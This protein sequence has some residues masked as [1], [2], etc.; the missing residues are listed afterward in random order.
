MA[1]IGE[2]FKET[3]IERTK[4]LPQFSMETIENSSLESLRAQNES[5][6]AETALKEQTETERDAST[7]TKGLTEEEK[8]Q[9]KDETGWSDEVIDAIRSTEECD[10]YKNAGLRE[11][12]INGRECLVRS[13]IDWD[14]QDDMGRTNRERAEA[15]LS[16]INKDGD[17]IELHHIGQKSDASLA[18][19]TPDEH[20]SKENYSVLHDTKKESEID[21]DVFNGERSDHWK[22]RAN[23]GGQNA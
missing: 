12:E 7:E 23:V 17:T 1:R 22:A 2:A 13:D 9:I 5:R 19:L 20:R 14:R 10:V 3:A 18:E 6:L 11:N 8:Q 21:R 16:P 15:G 4:E